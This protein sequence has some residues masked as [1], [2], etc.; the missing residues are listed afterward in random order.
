M[1]IIK[2]RGMDAMRPRSIYVSV[3]GVG[4]E[5]TGGVFTGTNHPAPPAWSTRKSKPDRWTQVDDLRRG[6]KVALTA[7]A[8]SPPDQTHV[9][10]LTEYMHEQGIVTTALRQCDTVNGSILRSLRLGAFDVLI[11]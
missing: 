1:D 2:I 7:T 4:M 6:R 11:G 5:Q 10:R 9:R 8:W 3:P